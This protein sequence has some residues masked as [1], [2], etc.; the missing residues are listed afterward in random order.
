MGGMAGGFGGWRWDE[1]VCGLKR[2]GQRRKGNKTRVAVSIDAVVQDG[3]RHNHAKFLAGFCLGPA[4][5]A[6]AR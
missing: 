6:A 3:L 2:C 4:L 5:R 1:V